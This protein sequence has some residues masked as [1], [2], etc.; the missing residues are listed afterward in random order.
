MKKIQ[1]FYLL[2][3]LLLCG[4]AKPVYIP[5]QT[6]IKT[7]YKDS[8]IYIRDTIKVY[9]PEEEKQNQTLADSS[10]LETNYAKSDAWVDRDGQLNHTLKNKTDIPVKVVR[11][12][13]VT[14]EYVDNYV[15]VPV[16]VKVPE[17]Y[18]P[19]FAW[20]CIIFTIGVIVYIITRIWLKFKVV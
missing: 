20:L 3:L 17:P 14:V 18:I 16:E 15:E 8:T 12:T 1:L 4:C 7:V 13:V 9:L 10:H 11:D 2:F 19:T 6:Q 5:T